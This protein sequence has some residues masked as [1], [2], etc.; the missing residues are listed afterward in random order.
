MR[1]ILSFLTTAFDQLW[2]NIQAED[3]GKQAARSIPNVSFGLAEPIV[4]GI[5]E[6][7]INT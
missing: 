6:L 4:A 1:F 5:S 7:L 2:K 3:N